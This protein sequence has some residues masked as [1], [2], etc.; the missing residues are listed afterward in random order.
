MIARGNTSRCPTATRIDAPEIVE[1]V[2]IG[3][4]A[5]E[6]VEI[7]GIGTGAPEIDEVEAIEVEGDVHVPAPAPAVEERT[8]GTAARSRGTAVRSPATVGKETE[9]R[10]KRAAAEAEVMPLMGA[11]GTLLASQSEH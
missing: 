11:S 1:I 3:T 6:I 10:I 4:G 7:V 9:T 2:G 8:V 5:P